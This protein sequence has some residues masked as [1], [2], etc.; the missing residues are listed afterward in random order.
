MSD[1]TKTVASAWIDLAVVE[2]TPVVR[3]DMSLQVAMRVK[4]ALAGYV[5]E[6]EGTSSLDEDDAGLLTALADGIN[7][8]L[9]AVY[10]ALTEGVE[11]VDGDSA[12]G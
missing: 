5:S 7:V 10:A 1:D 4:D 12:E 3:L 6:Y 9:L 8:R 2:K 11:A